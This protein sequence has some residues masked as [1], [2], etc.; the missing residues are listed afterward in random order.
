[1]TVSKSIPR[2]CKNRHQYYKSSHCPT[3]PVCEEQRKPVAGFAA[4]LAAPARRA[5]ENAGIRTLQ[6]LA[7]KN[8]ADILTLHGMGPS[9]I[10]KLREALKS[11]GLV[12]NKK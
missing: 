7:Q 6:Q 8:E 9:S 4:L 10:P 2:V 12:F 1:M 5:L 11:A 3:C